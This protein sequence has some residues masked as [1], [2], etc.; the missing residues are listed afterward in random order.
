MKIFPEICLATFLILFAVSGITAQEK[1]EKPE[2]SPKAELSGDEA[3]N[4]QGETEGQTATGPQQRTRMGKGG[5]GQGK[6][7]READKIEVSIVGFKDEDK[8]GRNDLFRDANG[9]G[10]ND[11]TGKE[12]RHDFKFKDDN[13]DKINDLFVDADGDGV[14][15]IQ[16]PF[17]SMKGN[18]IFEQVID[19]NKDFINDITG[20][21]YN[22]KS[23]RGYKFGFIKEE[24][25][26]IMQGFGDE[27]LDG[28]MDANQ[29]GN[30]MMKGRD[31]FIDKDGDGID[32]RRQSIGGRGMGAGMGHGNGGNNGNGNGNGNGPNN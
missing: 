20:L 15:D 12:Y 14:N 26:K 24:R 29:S 17:M 23:L 1:K 28:I 32:D 5:K 13:K 11:I 27:N 4:E 16:S 10:K 2:E 31:V 25:L 18:A 7:G 3:K 9:D 22:R 8:D 19:I 6:L 30:G 21:K